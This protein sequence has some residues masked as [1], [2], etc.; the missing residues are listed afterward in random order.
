MT[1]TV[2]NEVIDNDKSV[3]ENTKIFTSNRKKTR[4]LLFQELYSLSLN[5]FD[6]EL[7]RESFF[8]EVHTFNIDENYLSEMHKIVIFNE[9]FFIHIFKIYAPKFDVTKMSLSNILPVYI[10]LAEM[11]F[12]TEEIPAKVSINEAVEIAKVYW[13]DSSKKIVNGILNKVYKNHTELDLIKNEKYDNI[14]K[15]CFI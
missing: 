11:F 15:S 6:K 14:N 9:K 3:I 2:K 13:D 10:W 1:N 4:K 8:N 12:I 5:K 7:F